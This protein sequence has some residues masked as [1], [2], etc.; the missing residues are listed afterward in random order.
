MP[1]G[2]VHAVLGFVVKGVITT[3]S[4]IRPLPWFPWQRR[5]HPI[6]R[7]PRRGTTVA[8]AN[9]AMKAITPSAVVWT[10]QGARICL[11]LVNSGNVPI[12]NCLC[13]AQ[14]VQVVQ[15]FQ[16][17]Q[18]AQRHVGGEDVWRLASKGKSRLLLLGVG[19]GASTKC[20]HRAL[21]TCSVCSVSWRASASRG[22][23]HK[24]PHHVYVY[25]GLQC[26]CHH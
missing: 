10:C 25:V 6:V 22:A 21:W 1:S 5:R 4:L 2:K 8:R 14:L 26:F 19:C 13:G 17:G 23:T 12:Q 3:P 18:R 11:K 24:Q 15:L 7:L 16:V 20:G 9:A